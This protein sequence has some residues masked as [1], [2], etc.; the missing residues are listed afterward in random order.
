MKDQ[1][2]NTSSWQAKVT[3]YHWKPGFFIRTIS[4]TQVWER[5]IV[6]FGWKLE[7]LFPVGTYNKIFNLI[8]CIYYKKI[9]MNMGSTIF[10]GCLDD[11]N[12][13]LETFHSSQSKMLPYLREQ[14]NS[15]EFLCISYP[16]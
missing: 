15:A 4:M 7:R 6:Q 11:Y 3:I 9:Y 2:V 12:F 16:N 1:N 13:P 5:S 10:K 14:K 8:L